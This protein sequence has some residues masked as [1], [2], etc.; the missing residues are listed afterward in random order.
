MN[1]M[2]TIRLGW[3]LLVVNSLAVACSSDSAS[4]H[5][6]DTDTDASG[7]TEQESGTDTRADADTTVGLDETTVAAEEETGAC[8]PGVFGESRFGEACFQ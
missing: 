7:E 4:V 5:P 2:R 6:M 3:W 8:M 1:I